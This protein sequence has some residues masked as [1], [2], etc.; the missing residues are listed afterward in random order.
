MAI[1]L[2]GSFAGVNPRH[3]KPFLA[4]GRTYLETGKPDQAL[5]DANISIQILNNNVDTP[6][7]NRRRPEMILQLADAHDLLGDTYAK[8]GRHEEAQTEY[9]QAS[10]IR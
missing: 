6:A 1:T 4:R 2:K 3:A 9:Y 10:E 7:W 8:L 5:E